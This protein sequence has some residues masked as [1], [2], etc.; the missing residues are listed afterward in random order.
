MDDFIIGSSITSNVDNETWMSFLGSYIGS[1]IGALITLVGVIITISFTKKQSK[2]DKRLEL[3]PY[4]QWSEPNNTNRGSHFEKIYFN[5]NDD[6]C[7]YINTSYIIKNVGLGTLKDLTIES[8]YYNKEY[9]NVMIKLIPG[10][11]EKSES[12]LLEINVNIISGEVKKEWI[13]EEN[14]KIFVDNGKI[15]FKIKFKDLFNNQYQQ[16]VTI[17]YIAKITSDAERY[18][19]KL[20][21]LS[22]MELIK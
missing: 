22:E 8:F 13:S 21:K 2:E 4:L 7:Y 14:Y 11:L 17:C 6:D 5:N 19:F 20:D 1:L 3:M 15:K 9:K 10:V 18:R 12:I 16:I